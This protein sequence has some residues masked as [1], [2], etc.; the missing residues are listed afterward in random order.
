MEIELAALEGPEGKP[1]PKL[2][3][4]LPAPVEFEMNGEEGKETAAELGDAGSAI[5]GCEIAD[6]L[7]GEVEPG[8]K[9]DFNDTTDLESSV[10][11]GDTNEAESTTEPEGTAVLKDPIPLQGTSGFQDP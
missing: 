8:D 1:A 2:D 10:G 7:A 6:E 11:L 9:L 4:V 3:V 5:T